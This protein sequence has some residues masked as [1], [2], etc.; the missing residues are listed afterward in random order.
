MIVVEK[1]GR[2]PS[3]ASDPLSGTWDQRVLSELPC[4]TARAAIV[5]RVAASSRTSV[6]ERS[7]IW[8]WEVGDRQRVAFWMRDQHGRA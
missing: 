3:V 7:E 4:V 2:G 5:D 8:K 1:E 6:K